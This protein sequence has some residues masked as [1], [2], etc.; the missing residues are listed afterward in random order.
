MRQ[1]APEQAFG[2]LARAA[3]VVGARRSGGRLLVQTRA[4]EDPVI[5][6]ARRG[7]PGV[8]ATA[9]RERRSTMQWPPFIAQ[10]AI[11]GAG[12][13]TFIASLGAPLGLTVIGPVNDRWLVRAPDHQTLT[14]HLSETERP[15]ERLRIEVDPLRV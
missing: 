3:R 9:E 15:S 7:D 1:R 8:V 13:P 11:S 2:L 10:A 12:A 14:R 4:P 5:V 6:A